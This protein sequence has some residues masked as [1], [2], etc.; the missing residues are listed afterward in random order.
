MK[1]LFIL[2]SIITS[3]MVLNAQDGIKWHTLNEA[4]ELNKV[5]PRNFIVDVYTNW[6][7]WCK[8]MDAQT[9]SNEIIADYVNENYYAVKFNAEQKGALI[10]GEKEYKFVD[11][12]SRGYHEMAVILTKGRLSYPTIVYLDKDL[13]H[14][15]VAPGFVDA[16]QLEVYL[17]Y[18]NEGADK[19][20]S[21]EKYSMNFEGKV[22]A[23]K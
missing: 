10:V 17:A 7:G 22:A 14:L 18:F 3:S 15:E 21:F 20:T 16:E 19:K 11:N 4:I 2:L 6:C 12:G 23:A 5:E 9:F 8:R 13:R 1:K